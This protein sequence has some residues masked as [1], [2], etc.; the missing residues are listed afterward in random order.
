MR[1]LVLCVWLSGV[2]DLSEILGLTPS[3]AIHPAGC[4]LR[5]VVRESANLQNCPTKTSRRTKHSP[6][7]DENQFQEI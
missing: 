1:P 6:Q 3:A 2:F 7:T 5:D 4:I